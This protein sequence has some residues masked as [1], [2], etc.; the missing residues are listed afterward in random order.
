M[1]VYKFVLYEGYL[2]LYMIYNRI[3]QHIRIIL[4]RSIHMQAIYYSIAHRYMHM[5][6]WC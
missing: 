6:I 3:V 4:W 2:Q 1:H 5:H